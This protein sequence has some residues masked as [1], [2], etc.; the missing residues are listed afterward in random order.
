MGESENKIQELFKLARTFSPCIITIDDLHILCN[1]KMIGSQNA[2]GILSSLLNCIDEI[3]KN[4]KIFVIFL[5]DYCNHQLNR[6]H[7]P[8]ITSSRTTGQDNYSRIP[9]GEER[10]AIFNAYLENMDHNLT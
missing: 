1:K 4:D 3:Q 5:E 8:L 9:Q 10:L 6:Y 7:R 2:S